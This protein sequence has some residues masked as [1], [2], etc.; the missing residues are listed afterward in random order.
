MLLSVG[1]GSKSNAHVPEHVTE[2]ALRRARGTSCSWNLCRRALAWACIWVQRRAARIVT[3]LTRCGPCRRTA[4]PCPMQ[5]GR[6]QTA[7]LTKLGPLRA[8]CPHSSLPCPHPVPLSPA[9]RVPSD[10]DHPLTCTAQAA[11]RPDADWA[12]AGRAGGR[13]RARHQPRGGAHHRLG[14]A[15][16]SGLLG[17]VAWERDGVEKACD[18]EQT[19]A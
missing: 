15:R 6:C 13:L 10:T 7:T 12:A 4:I 16:E 17:A 11:G 3:V 1:V 5:L 19:I 2:A 8:P 9:G 14:V 18:A